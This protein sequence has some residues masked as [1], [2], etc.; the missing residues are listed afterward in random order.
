[1]NK[2]NATKA[3]PGYWPTLGDYQV[4]IQVWYAMK[5]ENIEQVE[6]LRVLEIEKG[7]KH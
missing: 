7:W 1:M 4:P 3:N 6:D 5:D 2:I